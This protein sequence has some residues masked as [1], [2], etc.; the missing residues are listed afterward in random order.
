MSK[1][2]KKQAFNSDKSFSEIE[3]FKLCEPAYQLRSAIDDSA[4]KEL[5]E[6]V[7][8]LGV[9]EPLVV[10]PAGDGYEIVAGHRRFLAAKRAGLKTVPCV[11]IDSDANKA[12]VIKLHE[13]LFREDLSVLDEARLFAYMR[14]TLHISENEIARRIKK[15]DNYVHQRMS[16]LNATDE[17]Q[18]ALDKKQ[19]TFTVARELSKIDDETAQREFVRAAVAGGCSDLTARMWRQQYEAQKLADET[20]RVSVHSFATPQAAQEYKFKCEMCE[21]KVSYAEVKSLTVCAACYA[22]LQAA[23]EEAE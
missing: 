4:L 10:A 5:V 12:D 22:A 7:S 14:D 11:I 9:I 23:K 3:L 8:A 18:E 6:S 1:N 15:S 16:L 19:I 2:K 20:P 17:L 13:N 21:Q